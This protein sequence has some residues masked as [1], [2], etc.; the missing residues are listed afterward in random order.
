MVI[1]KARPEAGREGERRG[2]S[3]QSNTLVVGGRGGG[4]HGSPRRWLWMGEVEVLMAVPDAS[5]GMGEVVFSWQSQM[6]V[7]ARRDWVLMAVPDAV[8][9]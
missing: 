4:L 5:C 2:F 9:F 3:W 8:C 6:M 1:F 7:A